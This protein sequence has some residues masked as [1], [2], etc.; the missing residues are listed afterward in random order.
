MF[1]SATEN[2]R[3]EVGSWQEAG[4]DGKKNLRPNWQVRAVNW[5]EGR[6]EVEMLSLRDFESHRACKAGQELE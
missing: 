6:G 4:E 2:L 5:I 1:H 3:P